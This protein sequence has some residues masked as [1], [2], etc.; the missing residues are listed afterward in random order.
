MLPKK[1]FTHD[2][3]L[4]LLSPY[5]DK[6]WISRFNDVKNKGQTYWLYVVRDFNIQHP[7]VEY[8]VDDIVRSLENLKPRV[9][10]VRAE[11]EKLD[12]QGKLNIDNPEEE[13]K[14]EDRL[15]KEREE[16][17]DWAEQDAMARAE[18][19]KL[20]EEFLAKKALKG[21][22]ILP[23]TNIKQ[24]PAHNPAMVTPEVKSEEEPIEEPIAG[25][26]TTRPATE[27]EKT[28]VSNTELTEAEKEANAFV[29]K[30]PPEEAPE[31]L[32]P[33]LKT[34]ETNGEKVYD[35]DEQVEVKPKVD[36][37]GL[38]ED[39]VKRLKDIG[40]ITVAQFEKMDRGQAKQVLGQAVYAKYEDT[41]TS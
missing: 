31:V 28:E 36:T 30:P 15:Q 5:A 23:V 7:K 25:P 16:H 37:I 18:Q 3:I 34:V 10:L 40:V 8:I 13:Q 19:R 21:E 6:R 20:D 12:A 33:V 22:E 27:E 24:D 11:M 32:P 9:S 17:D 41:L 38:P 1:Y 14:W 39:A 26:V 4:A 29:P 35:K 2:E